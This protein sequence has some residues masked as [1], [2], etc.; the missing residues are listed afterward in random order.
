MIEK[1]MDSFAVRMGVF[2]AF[3]I[4]AVI[5]KNG[6]FDNIAWILYGVSLMIRPCWPKA[7]DHAD[8]K[9]LRLGCRIAGGLAVL[10]GLLT[11]FGA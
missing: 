5:F 4:M 6:I 8:H 2:V 10:V 7:W 9:K 3:L 11:R 1:M